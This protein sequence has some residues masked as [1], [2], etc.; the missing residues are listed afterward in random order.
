MNNYW[1]ELFLTVMQEDIVDTGGRRLGGEELCK[2]LSFVIIL[3]YRAVH[4]LNIFFLNS[5]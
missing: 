3:V 4:I 5:L 2:Q 1:F